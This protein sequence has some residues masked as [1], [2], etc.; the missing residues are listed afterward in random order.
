MDVKT[1]RTQLRD[2]DETR[3][4]QTLCSLP[5]TTDPAIMYVVANHLGDPSPAVCEAAVE[6]LARC[7][8]EPAAAAAALHLRSAEP[9]EREYAR[10]ALERLG[11][12]SVAAVTLLLDDP[13]RDVRKYAVD[14]F[15]R[16]QIPESLVAL[17]SAL[18][19]DDP[20]VVAAAA[21]GL[22]ALGQARTVP[23]L[24][25]ALQRGPRWVQMA[26]LPSLGT[27]GGPEA[28][29]V[30]CSA[31]EHSTASPVLA[32]AAAAAAQAGL[33]DVPRA[34][35]FLVGLLSQTQAAW[36]TVTLESLA[37]LIVRC[38][39]SGSFATPLPPSV[40]QTLLTPGQRE[41]VMAA[42]RPALAAGQPQTRAAAATCLSLLDPA[43]AT[44]LRPD[45]A[46]LLADP[47]PFVRLAAFR[48]VTAL[49]QMPATEL[50]RTAGNE[51]DS[52]E[53]RLLAV[54]RLAEAEFQEPSPDEV[55]P[56][57]S[58]IVD[59]A[60][61][62]AL[63]AAAACALLRLGGHGGPSTDLG[64]LAA[65][66][67]LTD[68]AAL[69]EFMACPVPA[70][71]PLVLEVW[72]R[73]E[74]EART[75]AFE[76]LLPPAR[77][78]E[79]AQTPHGQGLLIRAAADPQWAIRGHAMRLLAEIPA[80]WALDLLRRA[81][82]DS[83]SRVR[84]AALGGLTR[85]GAADEVAVTEALTDTAAPVRRAGLL[86]A[87]T[88]DIAQTS[89]GFQAGVARAAED[90]IHDNHADLV[91]VGQALLRKLAPCSP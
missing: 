89:P 82:Q 88:L 11:R 56:T 53:I 29:R 54:R 69:A 34:L 79:L 3:R 46:R 65:E 4:R 77:A 60:R 12:Q 22:G 26:V 36:R 50:A 45:L 61:E 7:A 91:E 58:R 5:L 72:D 13:D 90:V 71:M 32:A 49:R 67:L 57:L 37:T 51:A 40:L 84:A 44:D 18:H 85:A 19:D 59:E 23:A 39:E 27:I 68:E 33:A 78:S 86:A 81:C 35:A 14:I 63:R 30:I 15:S 1:L 75:F 25:A 62:P 24:A 52:P 9:A 6:V 28:L 76:A 31:T 80:A 70:L 66:D 17:L 74:P 42:A 87:L 2:A 41:A 83:D 21:E 16:W 43:I 20:I 8:N 47:L 38:G 64:R 10:A 48:A 55:A 73:A